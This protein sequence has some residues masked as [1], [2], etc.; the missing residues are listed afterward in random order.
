M[1]LK[2]KLEDKPPW[3]ENLLY[4][5]Q[6]LAVSLPAI[7]IISKVLGAMNGS[8]EMEVLYLQKAFAVTG[9]AILIQVFWG[10]RLPLVIGPATVLLIGILASQGSSPAAIYSSIAISGVILALLA[11]TGLFARLQSLFTPRVVAVILLLVAFTMAPVIMQ[12]ISDGQ[13]ASSGQHLAFAFIFILLIFCGQRYLTGLWKSLLILVAIIIGS[14]GY[15]LIN[16]TWASA[17]STGKLGTVSFFAQNLNTSLVL[18]PG[19]LIAFLLCFL[20][21]SINDLGS[22]QA[23]GSFLQADNMSRRITQGI[24]ATGATNALAGFFGVIGPVN[25]SFSPGVIASTGCAAR[26]SLVPTGIALLVLAFLP[27]VLFYLS[28]IP[29]VVIGTVLLYIMCTQVAAGLIA[30]FDAL[31]ALGEPRFDNALL[32][33]LPIMAGIIVAFLPQ[34]VTASFP[35]TLQPI[36]G[37]GFVVGIVLSMLLEHVI[38]RRVR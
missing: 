22:I 32:I 19:V 5:L 9:I 1:E 7:I 13:G 23:V 16:P 8:L 14:L 15:F 18:E 37:N 25:F 17:A 27:R 33:G 30:A 26:R 2:Y 3:K 29:S 35:S 20:G 12:L 4:G 38:F 31:K 28:Y 10:H 34:T 36:L 11:I 6:W 24:T 21:L